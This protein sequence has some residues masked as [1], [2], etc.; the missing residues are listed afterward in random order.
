MH[1]VLESEH[2]PQQDATLVVSKPVSNGP[3][4]SGNT[5]K[6]VAPTN[7]ASPLQSKMETTLA[8]ASQTTLYYDIVS[9][10][11]WFGF[12]ILLRYKARWPSVEFEFIPFSLGGVM[13]LA[14]N[15]P[16]ARHPKKR[17]QIVKEIQFL[18]ELYDVDIGYPK[19][20]KS[21]FKEMVFIKKFRLPAVNPPCSTHTNDLRMQKS[22]KLE[23]VSRAFWKLYWRDEKSI[24]STQDLFTYL[25]PI[26]GPE[27]AKNLIEVESQTPEVKQ[28]LTRVTKEAVESYGSFGA[29]WIV[30]EREGRETMTFHGSDKVEAIA[31]YFG[32]KYEGPRPPGYNNIQSKL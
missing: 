13:Q 26:L 14:E 7:N 22:D 31:L 27:H 15:Q 2:V 12:E 20:N 21:V 4:L 28:E 11:S 5:E 9:P 6:H 3:F 29:P 30:C 19:G 10:Y 24:I 23:A 18:K 1:N 17:I 32:L 25:S 16:T 8:I